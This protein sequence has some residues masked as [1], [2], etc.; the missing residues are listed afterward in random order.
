MQ[1]I[2]F[3]P[4]VSLNSFRVDLVSES[5]VASAAHFMTD[6]EHIQLIENEVNDVCVFLSFKG[7]NR[8]DFI[9][10]IRLHLYF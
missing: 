3:V 5:D 4:L 7:S 2:A 10:M 8:L 1:I 6:H 9:S